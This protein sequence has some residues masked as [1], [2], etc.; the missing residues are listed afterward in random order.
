[1]Y[2]INYQNIFEGN[3]GRFLRAIDGTKKS[4]TNNENSTGHL[5]NA[6]KNHL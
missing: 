6:H 3:L 1:M 2:S 5:R 4:S